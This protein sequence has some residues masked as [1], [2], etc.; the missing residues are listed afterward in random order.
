MIPARDAA[1]TLDA[2]VPQVVTACAEIVVV[3]NTSSD[4]IV[5]DSWLATTRVLV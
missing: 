1:A 2:V 4:D 5:A 3:D